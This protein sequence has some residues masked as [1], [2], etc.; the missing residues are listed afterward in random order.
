MNTVPELHTPRCVLKE[1][2][3]TDTPVLRQIIDDELFQRFLPELYSLFKTPEGLQQFLNSFDNYLTK[4]EGIL[5]GIRVANTLVGFVAL[6]DLT[7]S[8][9]IFYTIHPKYRNRGFAKESVKSVV[10]Y[11][12]DNVPYLHLRTEVYKDNIASLSILYSCRFHKCGIEKD[13]VLLQND[14]IIKNKFANL[15]T[16]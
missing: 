4:N 3:Q 13:K 11:Y 14:V 10:D 2:T 15:C 7:F 16:K 5:W 1:I 12:M 9:I 8:P 6:M